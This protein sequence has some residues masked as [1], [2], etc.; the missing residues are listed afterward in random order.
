MCCCSWWFYA[1][2]ILA[3]T[4]Y[5]GS[6]ILSDNNRND[7][8]E[9]KNEQEGV[10][11]EEKSKYRKVIRLPVGHLTLTEISKYNGENNDRILMSI[12]GRIFDMSSDYEF[13]GPNG[14]N[15]CF[16]GGDSSYM[17]GKISLD[18]NDKNKKHF[19]K[20]PEWNEGAQM[21]LT[22]WIS[23]FYLKYP[24]VGR[25][26]EFENVAIE[27]WKNSGLDE[28]LI[29]NENKKMTLEELKNEKNEKLISV[30]G[31]I[32][33]ISS[34]FMVYN[35]TGDIPNAIGNDITFALIKD[36]YKKENYNL[37]LNTIF[38]NIEYKQRLK[39]IFKAYRETYCIIGR[40]DDPSFDLAWED[41]EWDIIQSSD[42]D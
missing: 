39:S 8:N 15:N 10:K 32:F 21:K 37:P 3:F 2:I 41:D 33:D 7:E 23:K 34:A 16:T 13:Y 31:Y 25:L 5:F 30:A 26:N 4:F 29:H 38:E 40:L 18:N 27:S 42:A 22:D 12:C 14:A 1:C 28:N 20:T 6:K 11:E 19:M 35:S 36:E 9:E 24:I 17:L